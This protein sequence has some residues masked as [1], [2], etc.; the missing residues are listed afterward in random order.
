[1]AQPHKE[2]DKKH[3]V[4]FVSG[5]GLRPQIWNEFKTRFNIPVVVEFYGATESNVG[6]INL[7]GH[8]GACGFVSV[9]FPRLYPVRILKLDPLTSELYRGPDGLCVP[10]KPGEPGQIAGKINQ[11]K[12]FLLFIYF[13]TDSQ[14]W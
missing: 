8:P 2:N 11:S 4:R 3:G 13:V 10:C 9:I 14:L 5:N 7:F 1:M 6:L 12:D